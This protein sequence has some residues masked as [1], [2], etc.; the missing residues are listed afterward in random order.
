MKEQIRKAIKTISEKNNDSYSNLCT[1]D[2]VNLTDKTCYCIPV[3]GDPDIM[4]VKLIANNVTGFLLVPAVGSKV[5]ISYESDSSA[6]VSMVSAVSEIQLNGTAFEGLVKIVELVTKLN[7]I[8]N[9]F[10]NHL[11]AYNVHTH[12]GVTVGTALTGITTPATNTLS[13]TVKANLENT[14]VKHG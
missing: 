2:S 5:Y 4:L 6:F 11:A 13:L 9:A 10:N 3:N 14:K 1:V 7:N 12:A 8:E